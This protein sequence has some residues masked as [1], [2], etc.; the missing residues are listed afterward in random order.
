MKLSTNENAGYTS[1]H[2]DVEECSEELL[3]QQSYAIENQLG[4]TKPHTR[5]FGTHWGV[6]CLHL[7][8]SLWHKDSGILRSKAP[9]RG[10]WMPELVYLWHKTAGEAIPRNIPR[11]RGGPV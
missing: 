6:N 1:V 10:L 11:H 3:C 2:L 4:N 5:G 8:G 7:A 9:I